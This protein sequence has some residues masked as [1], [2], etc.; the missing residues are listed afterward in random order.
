MVLCT[1]ELDDRIL[2]GDS[3][4]TIASIVAREFTIQL[5]RLWM[6]LSMSR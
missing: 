4:I 2:I 1:L 6:P 3:P 5:A